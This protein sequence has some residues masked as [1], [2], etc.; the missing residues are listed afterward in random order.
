M[1]HVSSVLITFVTIAVFI[2]FEGSST[3][4][5]YFNAGRIFAAL[6]LFNQ[7]TVPL[8][9]FPITVPIIIAAI[10]STRRLSEFLEQPEVHREF[11]GIRN[12]AR[13]LSRSDASLDVF[14][15]EDLRPMLE[16]RESVFLESDENSSQV[17]DAPSAEVVAPQNS[18]FEPLKPVQAAAKAPV[19]VKLRKN[20]Q[21]SQ[22][23]K[24][25]R[26]RLRQK[27]ASKEFQIELPQH[28]VVQ[29][30]T[31]VFTRRQHQ[32]RQGGCGTAAAAAA[33][34]DVMQHHSVLLKID[35]LDIPKGKCILL[36]DEY[37]L[38]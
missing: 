23:T 37:T 10:V 26:N 9:I 32:Q 18:Y 7:M 17:F 28:L 35:K 14:E 8:F 36:A 4:D 27:S 12:M 29:V 2:G 13:I 24:L 19:K 25:D 1:T 31:A 21:L 16:E 34:D 6:A 3:A 15:I 11:E 38:V 20:N 5:T 22:S 33:D 30:R